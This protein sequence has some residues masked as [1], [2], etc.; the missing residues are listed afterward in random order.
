MIIAFS[1]IRFQK[2]LLFYINIPVDVYKIKSNS[3]ELVMYQYLKTLFHFINFLHPLVKTSCLKDN[4]K[5]IYWFLTFFGSCLG[6]RHWRYFRMSISILLFWTVP[7]H[8]HIYHL[9][10]DRKKLR[11]TFS[12]F[13]SSVPSY[14]FL[15]R[16]I[17]GIRNTLKI[18]YLCLT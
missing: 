6:M 12:E 17:P 16:D 5:Q 18:F 2:V 4:L 11:F 13:P 14:S 10:F 3:F 7:C 9:T 8:F 1:D 15:W